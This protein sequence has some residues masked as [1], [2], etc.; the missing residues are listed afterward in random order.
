MGFGAAD[1]W[2]GSGGRV[3]A[4]GGEGDGRV[5]AVGCKRRLS[6]VLELDGLAD[7]LERQARCSTPPVPTAGAGRA[8]TTIS[9]APSGCRIRR[10]I[11]AFIKSCS[12]PLKS[13]K[14]P[15][16]TGSSSNT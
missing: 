12:A 14:P 6:A 13:V 1:R 2:A 7:Q 9:S 5:P 15:H 16:I 8:A 3:D 10:S 11:N 4:R